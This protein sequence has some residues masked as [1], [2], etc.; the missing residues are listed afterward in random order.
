MTTRHIS[1]L[2]LLQAFALGC[3]LLFSATATRAAKRFLEI[4][5]EMPL[6]LLLERAHLFRDYGALC[7]LLI[8]AW[9]L[10][11][12]HSAQTP[13]SRYTTT[14]TVLGFAL[15]LLFALAAT[16]YLLAPFLM[17]VWI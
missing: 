7:F 8:I 15:V 4:N 1:M 9:T 14:S 17:S 3:A 11:A 6:P 16:V 5:G 12:V 10:M 13:S 2:V